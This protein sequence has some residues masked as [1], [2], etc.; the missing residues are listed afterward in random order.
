MF[1]DVGAVSI[2]TGDA[3]ALVAEI[4]IEIQILDLPGPV[5]AER[6]LRWTTVPALR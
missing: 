4:E 5:A 1:A 3:A 2:D 6:C